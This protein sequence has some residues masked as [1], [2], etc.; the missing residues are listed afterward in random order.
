MA[1]MSFL[2]GKFTTLFLISICLGFKITNV[3]ADTITCIPHTDN[4]PLIW[5]ESQWRKHFGELNLATADTRLENSLNFGFH[6]FSNTSESVTVRQP[7][8]LLLGHSS[9]MSQWDPM[10]LYRLK[11]C[12]DVYLIDNLGI[13]HSRFSGTET[14]VYSKLEAMT[15]E[16]IGAFVHQAIEGIKAS[17]YCTTPT[18]GPSCSL[19]TRKANGLGWAMGGKVLFE[20]A[21]QYPDSFNKLINLGGNIAN[22]QGATGPNPNA[23]ITLEKNPLFASLTAFFIQR[24][25]WGNNNWFGSWLQTTTR[26]ALNF[27]AVDNRAVHPTMKEKTEQGRASLK[28]E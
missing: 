4:A 13:G 20:G 28:A 1:Q 25:A 11:S 5:T 19:L 15:W 9:L 10:I 26:T 27:Y 23:V 14:E 12:Y 2:S 24:D 6:H 7:L 8:I 21:A 3:Q 16:D 22:N 18:N 17:D